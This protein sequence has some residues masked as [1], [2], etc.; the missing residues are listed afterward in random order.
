ML[1]LSLLFM[2]AG[3][4]LITASGI[5]TTYTIISSGEKNLRLV[6]AP[7]DWPPSIKKWARYGGFGLASTLLGMILALIAT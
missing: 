6:L 1:F 2:L 4:T 3:V 7:K 5:A